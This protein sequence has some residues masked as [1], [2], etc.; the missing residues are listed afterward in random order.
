MSKRIGCPY[1][2]RLAQEVIRALHALHSRGMQLYVMAELADVD[3]VTLR[4]ALRGKRINRI[5]RERLEAFV[6]QK[7]K[8]AA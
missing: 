2:E 4:R 5:T 6:A 1:G 7:R 3:R 8:A